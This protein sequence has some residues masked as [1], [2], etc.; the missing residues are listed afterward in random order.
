MNNKVYLNDIPLDLFFE[1]FTSEDLQDNFL[2]PSLINDMRTFFKYD[3]VISGT[4]YIHYSVFDKT[5]SPVELDQEIRSSFADI[6]TGIDTATITSITLVNTGEDLEDLQSYL[7]NSSINLLINNYYFQR[8][9]GERIYSLL[10]GSAL[11]LTP[12]NQIEITLKDYRLPVSN[13]N[14]LIGTDLDGYLIDSNYELYSGSTLIGYLIPNTLKTLQETDNIGN[15]YFLNEAGEKITEFL[16]RSNF[17]AHNNAIRKSVFLLEKPEDIIAIGDSKFPEGKVGMFKLGE[18]NRKLL[19]YQNFEK[20]TT[21]TK[22]TDF[23][24]PFD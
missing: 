8:V 22:I 6:V 17:L 16:R 2:E 10:F 18:E 14:H 19:F 23:S 20:S 9:T 7:S 1:Y 21:Y 3:V 24:T 12:A 15:P 5:V 4:T 11:T 13:P